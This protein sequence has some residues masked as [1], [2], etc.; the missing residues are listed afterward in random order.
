M[1]P[2]DHP[3]KLIALAVVLGS[4]A[5][6]AH[7]IAAPLAQSGARATI[8]MP[9]GIEAR[10]LADLPVAP[11]VVP[12]TATRTVTPTPSHT[13]T[14]LPTHTPVATASP[15]LDLS[16]AAVVKGR[17]MVDGK[18]ADWGLG[19]GFGPGLLIERC[20]DDRTCQIIART[21]VEDMAGNFSFNVTVPIPAGEYYRFVWRNENSASVSPFSGADKW[22]GGYYGAAIRS[23]ERDQVVDLGI[24]D[25][26]DIPLTAPTNGSGFSGLP[27]EF[28]WTVRPGDK[29]SYR[30][31]FSATA[32]ETLADRDP[33]FKTEPLGAKGSYLM[34]RYPP[35]T[36]IGIEHKY[37]WFATVEYPDGSWGESYYTRMLWFF[38]HQAAGGG[39]PGRRPIAQ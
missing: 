28:R 36:E 27:W 2:T 34:E 6:A 5:W 24:V 38:V 11:S 33:F 25:I 26:T 15:T 10:R 4:L 9:F 8:Y 19:D 18:P 29:G 12:P 37:R 17:L 13:P 7:A 35:G 1:R 3:A 23:L 21:A 31:N 14:D 32:C 30:W 16:G 22:I 20:V 39:E